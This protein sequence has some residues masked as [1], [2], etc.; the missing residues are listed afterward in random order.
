M[1]QHLRDRLKRRL[2]MPLSF[3][4]FGKTTPLSRHFGF[5]R[6]TPID[7]YYIEK[8]IAMHADDIRGRV[9]EIGDATYSS[10]FGGA[11]VTKCDVLHVHDRNPLATIV[12]DL[13][14]RGTLP[15]KAFDCQIITQ[16]LHLIYDMRSAVEE[17]YNALRKGGILLLTS[18]GISQIDRD[19]W[20]E[21]WFWSITAA[22]AG[23]LFGDV[24][25]PSNVSVRCYG[26]VFAATAFLQGVSLEEVAKVKLDVVDEAYPVVVAVRGRR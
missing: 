20:G 2:G 1:G 5:D 21:N 25:G 7:R 19:E 12:G 8:F 13:S 23:R 16:T 4:D 3:G 9:L 11:S 15:V 14:K 17:L 18:P 24:F 26:N 10:R 6:G 22:S